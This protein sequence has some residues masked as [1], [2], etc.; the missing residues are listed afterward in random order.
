MNIVVFLVTV[1]GTTRMASAFMA[2]TSNTRKTL[3]NADKTIPV[4]VV[5]MIG[6]RGWDNSDYLSG[7]GG[8]DDDRSKAQEDYKE[9]A[10]R[11]ATFISRQ[12]KIMK[13]PQGQAFLEQQQLM[14]KQKQKQ[15]SSDT[16]DFTEENFERSGGGTRMGRMMAQA[17][18]MQN[19]GNQ[20]SVRGGFNQQTLFPLDNEDDDEE[21]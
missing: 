17:K 1:C 18:R 4:V 6:G 10:D 21:K 12:T 20:G 16:M 19:K 14:Q 5:E 9:F 11:R 7:L 15:Q 13:T 2:S 3:M 8:D